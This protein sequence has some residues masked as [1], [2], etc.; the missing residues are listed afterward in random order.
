MDS[1]FESHGTTA[2]QSQPERPPTR[3][4]FVQPLND[5]GNMQLFAR[6]FTGK[7]KF[8]PELDLWLI[9]HK[10]KW[11]RAE[12]GSRKHL[13][14]LIKRFLNELYRLAREKAPLFTLNGEAVKPAEMLAWAKCSSSRSRITAM[15]KL[16]ED[17]PAVS[18]PLTALDVDPFLLGVANSVLDLR[19][20][21][22][23]E[24]KPEFLI[25]RYSRASYKPEAKA[26]RFNA[27]MTQICLE[28]HDLRDF[29]QEVLGYSLSGATSEQAF[30]LLVGVG[31]NG[32]SSL[33]ELFYF[34]MG[35]YAAAMPSHA[36]LKSESRA[37]RND[38]ARM[39]AVRFASGAEANTG[40]VL[41]ESGI[42]R[43]TGGD[44]I[45]ARFIGREYFD[46]SME[47]KFFFS[48]NTLPRVEGAD[49]GIYR[50]LVVIPFDARFEDEK[51]DKNLKAK[52]KRE[53]DG[54]LA[55]AVEGFR[56]WHER[57]HLVKPACVIEA[58][59]AYRSEM[60]TAQA[61]IDDEC[62]IGPDLYVP[63]GALYDAYVNWAKGSHVPP[64]KMHLFGTLLQQKGIKKVKSGSW[65]WKGLSLKAQTQSTP[66]LKTCSVS[67]TSIFS[68]LP[69]AS[70][71]DPELP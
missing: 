71:T 43:T 38:L 47:A 39:P 51:D 48:V 62:T 17:H 30:F 8:V 57:G 12:N 41:D 4:K 60:D 65:K 50:R 23:L 63:V 5:F 21:K 53:A 61:F 67:S 1:F 31:A 42:K 3:G 14:R 34:L 22:L 9:W 32:K 2:A 40:K 11:L 24:N 52:L 64:A 7:I 45:T 28:R 36:F 26:P 70:T 37:I 19:T 54:I 6:T 29:L 58:C 13:T 20:G 55:W 15:L 49:H 68:N 66:Q 25:T 56:R 27:F 33:V 46:F 10:G 69:P 18:I 35:S 59:K 16:V 44:T